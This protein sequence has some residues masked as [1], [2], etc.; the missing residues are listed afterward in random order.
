MI[1]KKPAVSSMD[2]EEM[3]EGEPPSSSFSTFLPARAAVKKKDTTTKKDTGVSFA[4]R[5]TTVAG[6][7]TH[8]VVD[9]IDRDDDRAM[10]V[11]VFGAGCIGLY[12]G[13]HLL[14]DGRHDVRFV[15]RS[16]L[17]RVLSRGRLTLTD[18]RRPGV[19]RSFDANELDVGSS[20]RDRDVVFVCVKCKDTT[21]VKSLMSGLKS[22]CIVVSVQNGC[23]N[24][25]LLRDVAGGR[26]IVP[27]MCPYGVN[28]VSP[29]HLHRCTAGSLAF[30]KTFPSELFVSLRNAGLKTVL[31]DERA[32]REIQRFKRVVNLGNALNA[33]VGD[34][35]T[36]C[37]AQREY[38]DL[39]RVVW[40]E[41]LSASTENGRE[42]RGAINGRSI[43]FVM[44]ALSLPNWAYGLVARVTRT[45]DDT[46]KSSMLTDLSLRR[47]TEI[48]ELNGAVVSAGQ[49]RGV[50]M[51]VNELLVRL[52]RD[53]EITKRGSPR[54][55]PEDLI[56]R[57]NMEHPGWN[58]RRANI[59]PFIIALVL[60]V[61]LC[62]LYTQFRGL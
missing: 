44:L 8:A 5:E 40:E 37:L 10:K 32:M 2:D 11:G 47:Q 51:P 23:D 25:R 17:K 49:K 20:L 15:G 52:V 1:E 61:V 39:L 6:R 54:W 41:G 45:T 29:G 58:E 4:G 31:Y 12:I 22:T 56:R 28:E 18:F 55:K 14:L 24:V 42:P 27:G 36:V 30:E 9:V 48:E 7:Q 59:N 60:A 16:V 43:R 46:Y 35:L 33:V 19:T 57:L 13:G 3:S 21:S 62:Y 50:R 53:A 34:R 38:R 26:T